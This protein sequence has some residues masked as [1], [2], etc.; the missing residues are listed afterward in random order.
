MKQK[1]NLWVVLLLSW[2]TY[3]VAYLCRVNLSTVLDKLAAGLDVSVEYLG[4]IVY[5]K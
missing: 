4:I 2:M 5:L 3:V 1:R